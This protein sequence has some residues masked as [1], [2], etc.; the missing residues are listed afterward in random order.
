MVLENPLTPSLLPGY[1]TLGKK[2]LKEIR[3]FA[4]LMQGN[5][6]YSAGQKKRPAQKDYFWVNK[7]TSRAGTGE[8]R[9]NFFAPNC[10]LEPFPYLLLF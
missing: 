3:D 4:Q 7:A 10:F 1:D 8:A 5:A 2:G 6:I 9:G